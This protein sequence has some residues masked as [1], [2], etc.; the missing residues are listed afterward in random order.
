MWDVPQRGGE[1]SRVGLGSWGELMVYGLLG[2]DLT[3]WSV[4][5]LPGLVRGLAGSKQDE[6]MY[7]IISA[8]VLPDV[9]N[10][11]VFTWGQN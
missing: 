6:T 9:L 3:W 10:Q 2:G 11:T 1:V 4:L 8:V 7:F 5:D